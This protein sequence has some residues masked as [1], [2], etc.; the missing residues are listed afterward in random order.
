[1]L[2][3]GSA[4]GGQSGFS[5]GRLGRDR[6]GRD[7]SVI[8]INSNSSAVSGRCLGA[9]ALLRGSSRCIMKSIKDRSHDDS[10]SVN[11]FVIFRRD[12]F[13]EIFESRENFRDSIE[14]R[15]KCEIMRAGRLVQI[16]GV[17]RKTDVSDE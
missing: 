13:G 5:R 8:A 17:E 12:I 15:K 2:G 6:L 16:F 10:R 1:M 3:E 7:S 4:E 14:V 9:T 11:E